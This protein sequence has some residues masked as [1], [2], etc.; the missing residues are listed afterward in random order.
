MPPLPLA[1][2]RVVDF[3][4]TR[5]ELAG[6]MLADLGAEVLKVEAPGGAS[7]RYRPP[8]EKG[9][10]GDP[11]AS[12]YWA[13]VALGKKSVV[14]DVQSARDRQQLRRLIACADVFIE[15]DDPGTLSEL[16]LGYKDLVRENPT[17]VYASITPFGQ[18]GPKSRWPATE[19]TLEAAGGRIALQGD[20]D[21][22]PLPMG[23]PNSDFHSGGQAAVD[24]IVALNEREL[25]GAGQYLD[26]SMQECMVWTLMGPVGW[27]VAAGCDPPGVGDDRGDPADLSPI[28]RLFPRLCECADGWVALSMAPQGQSQ[29]GGVLPLVMRELDKAGDLDEALTR[30][31]W[32]RWQEEF[33]AGRLSDE[34]VELAVRRVEE[35][36]RARTKA[37]LV[38]LTL[39]H[40]LRLGAVRTTSDLI[41]DTHL[42]A[43]GFLHEI[44]G[45]LHP[46]SPVRD[47]ER[48]LIAPCSPSPRL[49]EHQHWVE[50]WLKDGSRASSRG[51]GARGSSDGERLGEAFA[52]LNV[53]DFSWIVAGPTMGKTLADHGATVVR[54]E[55]SRRPD[56]ARRLPPYKDGV[57][58]INRSQWAAMYNTSKLSLALDLSKKEGKVLARRLVGWADVVIESYSPGT[59]DRLGLG[60][61][62]LSEGR[63]DLIMLSTS[64]FGSGG[65]LSAYAGFG[66]QAAAM[67]GLHAITGWPDRPPCGPF[68][69]YTDVI[70]PKFGVCALAAAILDRRRGGSGRHIELS[71]AEAGVRFIEPLFLDESVNGNTATSRGMESD[72]ACPH[73]VY[74][75]RGTQ[76]FIAVA[77][78]T[79]AHWRGLCEVAPMAAFSDVSFDTLET[80]LG[81]R[82]RLE[83]AVRRWCAEGEAR[84]LERRLIEAGVPASVVQRPTDLLSD[85]HLEE[86]GFRQTLVHGEL[87]PMLYDAFA[88]RFSA[89]KTMLHSA[90]PC[91]G[92]HTEQVLRDLLGLREQEIA[93]LRAA[94]VLA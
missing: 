17:L 4:T 51:S 14:L 64:L 20:T 23:F 53:V 54:V 33:H 18:R 87:G 10:E 59:M 84:D 3:A 6:R 48:S 38:E 1:G 75:T 86:R 21:R 88:T 91:L 67:V 82:E 83:E 71:Q 29:G 63:S 19:L 11:E 34:V 8:F 46:G 2:T 40:K 24:I 37:E 41:G 57:E 61:D 43:R 94:D 70:A 56:L 12:L 36:L 52:G 58:G 92:E 76:R 65:P 15:S 49:G 27:A 74:A 26:T 77:V 90:A 44:A 28:A 68:G 80:R 55:S 69:P 13:S 66:Q 62:T 32:D 42:R 5:A 78:E 31:D 79:A 16:G 25:S 89:K 39:E 85:P 60:Y 72:V 7:A 45:R 35:S 50:T 30:V 73:G 93:D 22:P 9:R 47:S 81:Q